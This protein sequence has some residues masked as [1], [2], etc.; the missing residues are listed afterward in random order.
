MYT[1]AGQLP[2]TQTH[3]YLAV[4]D[5]DHEELIRMMEQGLHAELSFWIVWCR[6]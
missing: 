1:Y 5:A 3:T 4:V 2:A 6:L